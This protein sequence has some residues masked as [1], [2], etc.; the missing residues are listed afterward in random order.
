MTAVTETVGEPLLKIAR[1]AQDL[2]GSSG[3]RSLLPASLGE[4][5]IPH[6]FGEIPREVAFKF[7]LSGT[8]INC[9]FPHVGK[10]V[11]L[12]DD[13]TYVED[14][15][16]AQIVTP[17]NTSIRGSTSMNVV[18]IATGDTFFANITFDEDDIIITWGGT[19]IPNGGTL[20]FVILIIR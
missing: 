19:G 11:L 2:T 3:S 4:Q 16:Q 20:S 12:R 13:V 18:E 6:F 7:V 1:K 9:P 14:C 8:S 5:R 15:H 10:C 17:E